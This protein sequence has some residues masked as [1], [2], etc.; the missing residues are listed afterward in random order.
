MLFLISIVKSHIEISFI[1][2]LAHLHLNLV[3]N[4]LRLKNLSA[5][6]SLRFCVFRALV[7]GN[8]FL[9]L[10][11]GHLITAKL[12][13][14]LK[15]ENSKFFKITLIAYF[16]LYQS[17]LLFT[18]TLNNVNSLTAVIICHSHLFALFLCQ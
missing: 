18:V 10:K 14:Q 17:K 1:S 4:R 15:N 5:I 2:S 9:L 3:V 16:P 13:D 7:N 8:S 11:I 12:D 6:C